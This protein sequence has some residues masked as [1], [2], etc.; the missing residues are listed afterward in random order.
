MQKKAKT[1]NQ[2]VKKT[3][4]PM[5][6]NY[7]DLVVGYYDNLNNNLRNFKGGPGFLETWV[8]DEDHNRSL[9]EIFDLAREHGVDSLKITLSSDVTTEL[10]L[11]WLR[12]SASAYGA[13]DLDGQELTFNVGGTAETS[14]AFSGISAHYVDAIKKR[15]ENIRCEGKLEGEKGLK[16]FSAK[17]DGGELNVAVDAEGVI[18]EARHQG[19]DQPTKAVMDAFCE[20]VQGRSVQEGSDHAGIR[21]EWNLRDHT[22]PRKVKGLLTPENADPMFGMAEKMI[23]GIYMDYIKTTGEKPKRNFWRDPVPAEWLELA[24][25]DQVKKAQSKFIEGLKMLGLQENVLVVKIL[26]HTRFVLSYVQDQTKPNFGYHM[27]KLEKWLR[28]QFNFEVEL[29]LESIEDR[30]R[31]EERTKRT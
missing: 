5:Q 24:Y 23:R 18:R 29:Q 15:A 3:G 14:D 22:L 30:N 13:L 31:R 6:L 28:E 25:E 27:I 21:L 12:R 20:M 10:N 1:S 4:E 17:A 2:K 9:L 16:T 19:Y 8:H 7:Q 11:D 26:N